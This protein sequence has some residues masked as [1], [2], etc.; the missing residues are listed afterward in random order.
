[1]HKEVG[2]EVA[3][4]GLKEASR[5][6][7]P[8]GWSIQPNRGA[9][10]RQDAHYGRLASVRDMFWGC[11][12]VNPCMDDGKLAFG[13]CFLFEDEFS[14]TTSWNKTGDF[15]WKRSYDWNYVLLRFL[16]S[17]M[18]ELEWKWPDVVGFETS[19]CSNINSCGLARMPILLINWF[20]RIQRSASF[21]CGVC[22]RNDWKRI[23]LMLQG[24]KILMGMIS[25][26]CF[27][28]W[29]PS[30]FTS[31]F[32]MMVWP[33]YITWYTTNVNW[34]GTWYLYQ[35]LMK[36]SD[37]FPHSASFLHIGA[38]LLVANFGVNW[39]ICRLIAHMPNSSGPFWGMSPWLFGKKMLCMRIWSLDSW[40]VRFECE[41]LYVLTVST[42]G[43]FKGTVWGSRNAA[44]HETQ[45]RRMSTWYVVLVPRTW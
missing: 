8:F 33:W 26:V 30:D 21:L 42:Y 10:S 40:R 25:H 17:V 37:Q 6:K 44:T 20:H 13:G 23:Y 39:W 29:N 2:A 12:Q 38:I 19:L 27:G 34:P 18:V 32:R 5:L 43:Q 11:I 14:A 4:W 28:W 41:L 35:V 3:Q 45:L 16:W 1:M 7:S 9:T 24:V 22:T 15:I 31:G 36:Q